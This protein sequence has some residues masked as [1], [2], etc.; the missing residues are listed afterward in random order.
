MKSKQTKKA[1]ESIKAFLPNDKLVGVIIELCDLH[2]VAKSWRKWTDHLGNFL[3]VHNN[4][5]VV[6]S[7]QDPMGHDE[8]IVTDVYFKAAPNKLSRISNW[9]FVSFGKDQTNAYNTLYAWFLGMDN[10][11]RFCSFHN[12]TWLKNEPPLISGTDTLRPVLKQLGVSGYRQADI[13]HIKGP[14]AM[15]I[16]RSWATEWPPE[17][18]LIDEMSNCNKALTEV[19]KGMI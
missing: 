11:L 6:S 12:G 8:T 14:V 9:A 16:T 7:A 13:L 2:P 10:R 18:G 17:Q 1:L 15:N 19:V 4:K 3:Q 5:K